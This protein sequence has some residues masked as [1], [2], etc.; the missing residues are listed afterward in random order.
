MQ[1]PTLAAFRK[2]GAVHLKLCGA[3]GCR[4]R[5]AIGMAVDT[6]GLQAERR[7]DRKFDET[8]L[9]HHRLLAIDGNDLQAGAEMKPVLVVNLFRWAI[10][11][12]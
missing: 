5:S 3:H 1:V 6:G 2:R 9:P 11:G 12:R 7:G 8:V 4:N 10:T